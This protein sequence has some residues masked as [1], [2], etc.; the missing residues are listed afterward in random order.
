MPDIYDDYDMDELIPN[1][2]KP[3]RSKKEDI[4][5]QLKEIEEDEYLPKGMSSSS[6][7]LPSSFLKEQDKPNKN[8]KTSNEDSD[9]WFNELMAFSPSITKNRGKIQADL[10]ESAG[11]GG[12]KK[13]KKKKGKESELIDYKRELEPEMALY[14]NLLM[15]QNRF[16][17]ALQKEYDQLTSTK[18]TARGVSKTLADLI[19]NITSA[20]ALSMQLVEKNVNAKKLIAELSLKQKKELG[21]SLDGS[22]ADMVDFASQYMKQLVSNRD[23]LMG[24]TEDAVV[25]EFENDDDLINELS[26]V[27]TS[28]GDEER[29]EDVDKYLKYENRNVS[30]YVVIIDNDVENYQFLAKDE[31]G[32]VIHDY[33][34]PNHTNISVNRST[35]IATDTYGKKYHIIWE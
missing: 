22:N 8:S 27:I 25:T 3:K 16:T 28:D 4:L 18:S 29:N 14:K 10:F 5:S 2:K 34:L 12:K 19:S 23:S 15:D 1:K 13:K 11:I 17:Q 31:D 7:F 35:N 33:P 24:N 26:Q 6:S 30:V 32:E 20:R 21:G 9:N